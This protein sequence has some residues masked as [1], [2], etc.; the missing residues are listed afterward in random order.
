MAIGTPVTSLVAVMFVA[1][2]VSTNYAFSVYSGCL[3]PPPAPNMTPR[4]CNC[5]G[6][7]QYMHATGTLACCQVPVPCA[8]VGPR[9][10]LGRGVGR[11]LARARGTAGHH[12]ASDMSSRVAVL[13][14]HSRRTLT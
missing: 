4:A 11:R 5:R 12:V 1:S 7:F 8:A 2:L 13:A 10:S 14:A 3:T 6:P 9:S